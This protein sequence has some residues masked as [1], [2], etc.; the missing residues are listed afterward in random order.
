M[1]DLLGELLAF[2]PGLANTALGHQL[3]VDVSFSRQHF[4]YLRPDPQ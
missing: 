4:L 1:G 3:L 2:A